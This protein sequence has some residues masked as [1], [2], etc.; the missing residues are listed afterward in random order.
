M[1][2]SI[3]GSTPR[4]FIH[5]FAHANNPTENFQFADKHKQM[6]S[7]RDDEGA[8]VAV[9]GAH[10]IL[11]CCSLRSVVPSEKAKKPFAHTPKATRWLSI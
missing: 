2:R 7:Q 6:N 11:I 1:K 10:E 3:F 4:A 8:W 9:F 5:L